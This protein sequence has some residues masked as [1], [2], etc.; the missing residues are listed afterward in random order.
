MQFRILLLLLL[1]FPLSVSL[2]QETPPAVFRAG[3]S[4]ADITP[5]SSVPLWGYEKEYRPNMMSDGV[6]D[7]LYAKAV[8]IHAGDTKCAIVGLDLGRSPVASDIAAIR[9][10]VQEKSGIGAI[11]LSASHTHHG[12]V[13][14]LKDVEGQGKGVYDDAAAYVA[15]LRRKLI[16]VII[17]AD[18]K[19][20]P[21][22]VGWAV[23]PCELNRNRH[24]Q[25]EPVPA[26]R[27]VLVVRFDDQ[28]GK[29]IAA[30]VNYAAHPTVHPPQNRKFTAEFPGVMSREVE[31]ALGAP[32]AFIQGAAGDLQ[33]EMDD[34]LWGKQDFMEPIGK[35]LAAKVIELNNAIATRAPAEP[36]IRFMEESF[37]FEM[38]MDLLNPDVQSLFGEAY[39]PEIV[40]AVANDV[41][42]GNGRIH[43]RL[44]TVLLNGEL[45]IVGVSGEFF[46]NHAIRLKQ[47]ARGVTTLFAGYCNG[48]HM[49]FP[50]I[51]AAAEGGY[52]ASPQSA[53][54]ELGGPEQMMHSALIHLY[55]MLG[56]Y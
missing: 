8:V 56:R 54:V 34:S 25:I 4:Q 40:R 52:G 18:G 44:T 14:E 17:D 22:R 11:I 45:F 32:C 20:V 24:S 38:R 1:I 51:E 35:A 47:R 7:P 2:A 39:F 33:C 49:Y 26:D 48:H 21:A 10:A 50:T 46:C 43:P 13:L 19:A 42:D 41:V 6:L 53:W 55:A 9:S 16:D 36:S 31:K 29:P 37:D 27:D 30:L 3:F 23:A 28:D 15:E 12:P 5:T